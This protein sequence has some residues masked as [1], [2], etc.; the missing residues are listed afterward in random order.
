MARGIIENKKGVFHGNSPFK[1][2]FEPSNATYPRVK[3][4]KGETCQTHRTL[5]FDEIDEHD[6]DVRREYFGYLE[7][8]D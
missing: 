8:Y 7:E 2:G 5:E 6:P 3:A 1:Y 4:I